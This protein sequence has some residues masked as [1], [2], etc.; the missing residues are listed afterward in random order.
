MIFD[1]FAYY[2]TITILIH[3]YPEYGYFLS[4]MDWNFNPNIETAQVVLQGT[5]LRMEMNQEFMSSL[6]VDFDKKINEWGAVLIHELGHIIEGHLFLLDFYTDRNIAGVATDL[7]INQFQEDGFALPSWV[8]NINDPCWKKYNLRLAKDGGSALEY[9]QILKKAGDCQAKPEFGFQILDEDGNPSDLTGE[10]KEVV[11]RSVKA[12]VEEQIKNS[13]AG[14]GSQLVK[15]S[16]WWKPTP[17]KIKWQNVLR[18]FASSVPTTLHRPTRTRPSR[19]HETRYGIRQTFTYDLLVMLDVSG[20]V[21]NEILV[22]GYNELHALYKKGYAIDVI[23]V[24]TKILN[25]ETYKGK[26]KDIVRHG[27]GG[28]CL[29]DGVELFV[30][31]KYDGLVCFTDGEFSTTSIYRHPKANKSLWLHYPGY[32]LNMSLP[33]QKISM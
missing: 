20:S 3:K 8:L 25:K 29:K 12:F 15:Q 11:E 26:W 18:R 4:N 1:K 2:H 27:Y 33:G 6:N 24:D 7:F 10:Q 28:T 14:T 17:S 19:M 16:T 9:Y 21:N 22:E 32:K 5:S 30:K 23:Q 31:G 13:P